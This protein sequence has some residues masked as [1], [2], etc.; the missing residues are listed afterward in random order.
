MT[1]I[2]FD[3]DAVKYQIASVSEKKSIIVTHKQSGDEQE[4]DNRTQ[5]YGD[6]RKKEGGWLAEKNATR[7]SPFLVEEFDI[8]DRQV[9]GPIDHCLRTVKNHIKN[10]CEKVGATSYYGY[11]GRGDSWRVEASTILKYKGTRAGTAKPLLLEEVEEYLFKHH[12]GIEQR[13]LESDD[14]LV[15]DCTA[16]PEIILIGYEKDYQ[17]CEVTLFNPDMMEKP[18]TI[19]GLGELFIDEKGKVRG[20]GRKF[21][22]WQVMGLDG[23]DNYS[24]NS[25]TTKKW[26]EK[27]AY[28]LLQPCKTDKECW[29]AL[30]DGYKNLYPEPSVFVGWRGDNIDVTWNY[31]LKENVLMAH[32]LRWENDYLN[33]D[34][35]L[36]RLGVNI[37]N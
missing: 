30:V 27:S 31:M 6:W 32:L 7:T 8:V 1:T 11:V 19:K 16:N 2:A 22:Y 17:G 13:G 26:G 5:F 25:A 15:M 12:G 14:V 20:Y 21:F 33:V 10:V 18:H 34:E 4:F 23:I 37:G 24:A 3:Y 35:I 36:D 29:Q 9:A 28:K